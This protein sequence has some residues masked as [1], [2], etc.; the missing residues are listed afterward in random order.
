MS[1][2]QSGLWLVTDCLSKVM[3]LSVEI[4][5]DPS[6]FKC[7]VG[8]IEPWDGYLLFC[9][10]QWSSSF[11]LS[12]F[13]FSKIGVQC[14]LSSFLCPVSLSLLFCVF[15]DSRLS[16]NFLTFP[17]VSSLNCLPF[18]GLCLALSSCV[19][20]V[21]FNAMVSLLLL[22]CFC[23]TFVASLLVSFNLS[24]FSYL[25]LSFLLV[26]FPSLHSSFSYGS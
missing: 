7:F 12:W 3:S 15:S 1:S 21:N 22:W 5:L 26:F 4:E 16:V 17:Y 24:L 20:S 19:W 2:W 25:L 13:C 23:C 6:G 11:S 8:A 9:H 14:V 10:S 18:K